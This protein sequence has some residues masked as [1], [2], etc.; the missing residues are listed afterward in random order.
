MA[1]R[2]G[3]DIGA[4]ITM[5]ASLA[6]RE[7]RL[8]AVGQNAAAMATVAHVSVAGAV[9]AGE[10][11]IEAAAVEPGGFVED[12]LA[13][14]SRSSLTDINGR[15]ITGEVLVSALLEQVVA[16]AA[17]RFGE[18]PQH[19][20]ISYPAAWRGNETSAL[21]SAAGR[22]GI[23]NITLSASNEAI[24]IASAL[25]EGGDQL[26]PAYLGAY[27]AAV[28]SSKALEDGLELTQPVPMPLVTREDLEGPLP[29]PPPKPTTIESIYDPEGPDTVFEADDDFGDTEPVPVVASAPAVAPPA[30]TQ[31]RVA[32]QPAKSSSRGW[33]LAIAVA[34]ATLAVLAGLLF[35]QI[36]SSNN[37]SSSATTT[38]D[39]VGTTTPAVETTATQ[40]TV[41]QTTVTPTT[42]STSTTT[43]TT[44]TTLPELE[45]PGPIALSGRGIVLAPD[46]GDEANVPF[47][48]DA[49]AALEQVAIAAGF[50]SSD[51]GFGPDARCEAPEVRIVAIG[52]LQLIFA[53]EQADGSGPRRFVQWHVENRRTAAPEGLVTKRGAGV[54][55]RAKDLEPF[56]GDGLVVD[57]DNQTYRLN[58]QGP[59]YGSTGGTNNNIRLRSMTGGDTCTFG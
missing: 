53:G 48:F 31:R 35:L 24:A 14:L 42:T 54:G 13:L 22:A 28:L 45:G 19:V 25:S 10:A 21:V 51:S 37:N 44:T 18:P 34:A 29:E 9:S 30:P 20:V 6:D 57:A 4:S 41:T 38:I 58:D 15:Q 40:T 55:V 52:D 8:L 2:L 59:I 49:D 3:I 43:S 27:G 39:G 23:T 5:A 1:Y 7:V 11:A 26:E 50:P 33:Y 36:R 46:S 47:G 32:P 16:V 17:E 12:P 56:Y